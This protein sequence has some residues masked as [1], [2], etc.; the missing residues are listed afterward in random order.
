[1]DEWVENRT[2][3]EGRQ[4]RVAIVESPDAF[5]IAIQ[6]RDDPADAFSERI[7]LNPAETESFMDFL[8]QGVGVARYRA[9]A[10]VVGPDALDLYKRGEI[11]ADE[12]VENFGNEVQREVND[13]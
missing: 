11:T 12:L 2:I 10:E 5:G 6:T 7:V 4:Y 3:G 8:E 9:L 1:M 13:S